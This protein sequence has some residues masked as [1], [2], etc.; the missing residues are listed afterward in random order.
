MSLT[1]EDGKTA[2]KDPADE[3]VFQFDWDT[4][5]LAAGVAISTSSFTITAIRP[6]TDTALTKDLEGFVT[7]SNQRK[8]QL[9][10]KAGTAG[11]LYRIDNKIVT[12]ESPTQTKERSFYLK[13]ENL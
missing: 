10:L 13:V 7:G 1:I 6:S 11:A 12:N 8:T 4:R 2:V 5:H 9:R 3:S